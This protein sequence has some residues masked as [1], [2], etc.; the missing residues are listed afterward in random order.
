MVKAGWQTGVP[1]CCIVCQA[2]FCQF[3]IVGRGVGHASLLLLHRLL[4][5]VLLRRG[6]HHVLLLRRRVHH[7]VVLRR[8]I[9]H[10]HLHR[11]HVCCHGM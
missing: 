8:R 10:L 2:C 7:V 3:P 5:L 1:C 4:H 9:V 11:G 6:I